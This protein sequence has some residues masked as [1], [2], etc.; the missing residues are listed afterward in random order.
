MEKGTLLGKTA[1]LNNPMTEA[2]RESGR[3]SVTG[4]RVLRAIP[5]LNTATEVVSNV[6]KGDISK[7]AETSANKRFSFKTKRGSTYIQKPNN[8]TIRQR[9]P[10]KN[11]GEPEGPPIEQP[12]SIKTVYLSKTDMNKIG[13]LFQDSSIPTR[14][15]PI[16]KNNKAVGMELILT[17][18]FKGNPAGTKIKGTQV[19]INSTPKKGLHPV[20][21]LDSKNP[22]GVHFGNEIVE[23]NEFNKGGTTMKNNPP[24]GSLP[25]EVADDIPA[26]IS[27]GEFVIPADVVRYVGLDK[28][29]GM[30]QEAK[31]GLKAMEH[32]GLIV[33]VDEEGRPEQPQKESKGEVAI[34]DVVQIEKAEPMVKELKEGGVVS[35]ILNPEE[36]VN[37]MN[38]GGMLTQTIAPDGSLVEFQ[39]GGM[40]DQMD[41]MMGKEMPQEAPDMA[42]EMPPAQTDRMADAPMLNAPLAQVINDVPHVLAY[43][44]EDEIKALHSA[45]RG[46]DPEGKQKLSPEGVPVFYGAGGPNDASEAAG[47]T[48]DPDEGVGGNTTD[49]SDDTGPDSDPMG[50]PDSAPGDSDDDD[51]SKMQKEL[52]KED[53]E[54]LD[55]SGSDRIYKAGVGFIDKIINKRLQ[56]QVNRPNPLQGMPQYNVATVAQGGLMRSPVYLQNGGMA[57]D[58]GGMDDDEDNRRFEGPDAGGSISS[59]PVDTEMDIIPSPTASPVA[60]EE[61]VTSEE[62]PSEPNVNIQEQVAERL[63]ELF[64]QETGER[65]G[66]LYGPAGGY[67]AEEIIGQDPDI[68][69]A[70]LDYLR[71]N[72]DVFLNAKGRVDS[73]EDVSYEDVAKQHFN[74]FGKD[75]DRRGV[76]GLMSMQ[77]DQPE[78]SVGD[79]V[80]DIAGGIMSPPE[81]PTG[82]YIYNK[83]MFANNAEMLDQ[84]TNELL[85]SS[86]IDSEVFDDSIREYRAGNTSSLDSELVDNLNKLDDKRRI[87]KEGIT[88]DDIPEGATN[89]D[90]YKKVFFNQTDDFGE[91]Y[92]MPVQG[93][94]D[95]DSNR[96][97]SVDNILNAD[98]SKFDPK[99]RRGAEALA[100]LQLFKLDD[101]ASE[102]DLKYINRAIK[103][104]S[105][106]QQIPGYDDRST[107]DTNPYESTSYRQP[108][109][110]EWSREARLQRIDDL[111]EG[112]TTDMTDAERNRHLK[113]DI[114]KV[115]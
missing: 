23:V 39:E 68:S 49:Q 29:H 9:V 96:Y 84:E 62:A 79:A 48:T 59:D 40:V 72:R 109:T 5:A 89:R 114:F 73:D 83:D 32:E 47:E 95:Y 55:P 43:L 101:P 75:E 76:E 65:F 53:K 93:G 82:S 63:P 2:Q 12:E 37:V 61:P 52:T 19:K 14:M 98:L 74:L 106:R 51:I 111:M 42:Q 85:R 11:R 44:Q 94:G 67:R 69:D 90:I 56:S 31:M 87:I 15:S 66:N 107:Y 34:I 28:I 30:M 80:G 20:E 91:K 13:P 22:K 27:E 18:E 3:R 16:I 88:L 77:Q 45:G 35:P 104:I 38:Q 103:A 105:Q 21:I 41:A 78:Q 81:E 102:T 100:Y 99:T 50:G 86:G 10:D 8:T 17:K 46:L 36:E 92:V 115:A 33:D 4:G 26:M 57:D 54:S 24:V 7:G 64:N 97:D 108:P 6:A 71:L 25:E 112:R 58:I 1:D 60:S 113:E 70:S 110:W